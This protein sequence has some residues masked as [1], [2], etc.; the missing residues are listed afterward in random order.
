MV[1]VISIRIICRYFVGYGS[2]ICMY[3]YTLWDMEFKD[4]WEVCM[5]ILW[6]MCLWNILEC[7]IDDM[8]V[9]YGK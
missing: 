2:C 3:M 6:G 7:E 9:K 8:K 5:C 1:F 4:I